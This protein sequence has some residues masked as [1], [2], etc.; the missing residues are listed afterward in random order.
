[1]NNMKLTEKEKIVLYECVNTQINLGFNCIYFN[2]KMDNDKV[3]T[4]FDVWEKLDKETAFKRN[5]LS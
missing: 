2:G 5:R 3:K 1:M 4:L